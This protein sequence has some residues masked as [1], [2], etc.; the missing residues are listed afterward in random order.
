MGIRYSV[1]YLRG[2]II[3]INFPLSTDSATR[4]PS[5]GVGA[6]MGPAPAARSARHGQRRL[7]GVRPARRRALRTTH[8][9]RRRRH[10]HTVHTRSVDSIVNLQV[11]TESV[12]V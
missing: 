7:E 1:I 12:K 4:L 10:H 11:M 3:N 8:Q 9:P 2:M 6:R 5:Q